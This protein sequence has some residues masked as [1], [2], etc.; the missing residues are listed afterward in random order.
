MTQKISCLLLFLLMSVGMYAQKSYEIVNIVDK[1]GDLT[2]EIRYIIPIQNGRFSNTATSNSELTGWLYLDLGDTTKNSK[3]KI[4]HIVMS[5]RLFEY[6]K[7]EVTESH[8]WP[9][10]RLYDADDKIVVTI[11]PNH[12]ANTVR[13]MVENPNA[14]VAKITTSTLDGLS[15]YSWN[16][17]QDSFTFLRE[18]MRRRGYFDKK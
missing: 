16:L 9:S 6:D 3:F 17:Y 18:Y 15:T 14:V 11:K 1:F 8:Y 7:Y 12:P 13:A 10:A 5:Y 4:N 2:G